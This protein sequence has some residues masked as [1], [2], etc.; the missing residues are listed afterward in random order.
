M[1]EPRLRVLGVSGSPIHNSNTDLAV[2]TVLEATGCEAEFVKLL[3]YTVAPC[4]ACLGCVTTN[5]CVIPDDGVMLAEKAKAADALVVGCYTPYS[6]IDART[7]AFLERLYPLRH[8]R[9]YMAGKP[10]VAVVTH[11]VPVGAEMLPPAA[12]MGTN[13]IMSYMME[14]GMNFL[15]GMTVLGNVPCVRCGHGDEC[16]MTGIK[17]LFGPRATVDSVGLHCFAQD[18]T[19]LAR[20]RELGEQLGQALRAGQP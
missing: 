8:L 10:G 1:T 20:A 17:M 16:D 7:K 4:R 13:A 3:D 12:D 19:L 14:E 18:E 11:A 9:G 6:T 5:C 2:Q 15:G